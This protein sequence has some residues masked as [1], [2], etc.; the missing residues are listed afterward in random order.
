MALPARC[1]IV[2][3][4]PLF[5]CI[6][7]LLLFALGAPTDGRAQ[8]PAGTL[9]SLLP[10]TSG[11]ITRGPVQQHPRDLAVRATYHVRDQRTSPVKLS[12][13]YGPDLQQ[14]IRRES[15]KKAYRESESASTLSIDGHTVHVLRDSLKLGMAAFPGK[16]AIVGQ[17]KARPGTSWDRPAVQKHLAS[18]FQRLDLEHLETF[19]P[20][21]PRADSGS[22]PSSDAPTRRTSYATDL[23][24]TQVRFTHPASWRVVDLYRRTGI[25]KSI[26]VMRDPQ[27]AKKMLAEGRVLSTER[28]MRLLTPANVGVGISVIG[29]GQAPKPFLKNVVAH[30]PL[31]QPEVVE[32][33]SSVHVPTWEAPAYQAHVLGKDADGRAV[34]WRPI[35]F[36]KGDA[37]FLVSILQPADTSAATGKTVQAIVRSLEVAK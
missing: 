15:L 3:A 17:G 14:Q 36:S 2:L 13:G 34:L 1:R 29:K 20:L 11:E 6:V 25:V 10:Q 21:P 7:V 24:G 23:D 22:V 8:S 32:A 12:L 9:R 4:R 28:T 30:P 18:L 37:H 16:F 19:T 27:A 35:V 31:N 26:A 33:P 5:P